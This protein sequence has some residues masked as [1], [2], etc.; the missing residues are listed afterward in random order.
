MTGLYDIQK[1]FEDI[2]VFS[3]DY[4]FPLNSEQLIK[5]WYE[6]KNFFI[7]TFNGETIIRTKEKITIHL[8]EEQRNKEFKNFVD[9]LMD[10][11]LMTN[12]LDNFLRLN[13]AGLFEN[14]VVCP[15]PS[16]GIGLG[17]KLSKA[18]RKFIPDED[19]VKWIQ[20]TISQ[21]VQTNKVEGYLYLSVDPRDFLLLSENNTNWWSCQSL[22]GDF[23]TGNLSYMVDNTTIIAYLA[24]DKE[25]HLKCIPKDMTWN[26]KKWRMLIHIDPKRCV[27]FNRQYPFYSKDLESRVYNLLVETFDM[28]L[29]D[30]QDNCFRGTNRQKIIG[31]NQM[32]VGG[33]IFD[34]KDIFH[35]DEYL[36]YC[37]LIYS[38]L[39]LPLVAVNKEKYKIYKL[40]GV[41]ADKEQ[42]EKYFHT[43]YDIDIG[44]Y[45][46]CPC[47]GRN[48]L[49][50]TNTFLCQQCREQ[51]NA[52]ED[53]YISCDCCGRKFYDEDE[54]FWAD[55]KPYCK[56]CFNSL[57]PDYEL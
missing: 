55:D 3:Q 22:D 21:L 46:K 33:R 32:Y 40:E 39:Y 17:A 44:K 16:K 10:T 48:Y 51:N 50:R 24:N 2:L 37:D 27:Y 31:T 7:K 19:N 11:G 45:P 26:S 9:L 38:P 14:K 28:Q 53:F 25:E 34:T 13:K 23:K 47:C 6:A 4:P 52:E 41:I 42:E 8:T 36:G 35:I 56:K 49:D 1:S 12:E 57:T 30:I 18:I 15:Y 20:S 29:T 5:Q 43:L 54:I